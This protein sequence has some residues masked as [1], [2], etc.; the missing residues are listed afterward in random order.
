[1]LCIPSE[2]S[3][4]KAVSGSPILAVMPALKRAG[5]DQGVLPPASGVFEKRDYGPAGGMITEAEYLEEKV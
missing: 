3:W 1:M 2:K 4:D 5:C